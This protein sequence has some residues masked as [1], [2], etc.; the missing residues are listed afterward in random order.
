MMLI[1]RITLLI[2]TIERSFAFHFSSLNIMTKLDGEHNHPT[3]TSAK[4]RYN[5]LL[6]I[7]SIYHTYLIY[8]TSLVYDIVIF[9]DLSILDTIYGDIFRMQSLMK[10]TTYE[11]GHIT[12]KSSQWKRSMLDY[13]NSICNYHHLVLQRRTIN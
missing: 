9:T 5:M 13:Q 4:V 7:S 10:N 8:L 11:M 2:L 6:S 12:I 1:K 3:T